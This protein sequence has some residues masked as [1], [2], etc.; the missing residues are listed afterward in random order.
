MRRPFGKTHRLLCQFLVG[1]PLLGRSERLRFGFCGRFYWWQP[2]QQR[3]LRVP[4]IIT[5]RLTLRG[6]CPEDLDRLAVILGDPS[7]M[8]YMPGGKPLPR[9]RTE[10]SLRKILN[11]WERRGYGRWA[12]THNADQC[13]IGWCG[14]EYLAETDETAVVCLLDSPF[15]NRGL[16]TEAVHASLR[17]AF[18][19]LGL[20]RVVGLAH[21]E[22]AAS[23]RLMEKNG[24]VFQKT[25]RLWEM[26]LVE[27]AITGE[28]FQS[29]EAHYRVLR[30]DV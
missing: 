21:T 23:R 4:S 18:E 9:R 20:G 14:L 27:Y 3:T 22:N 7:V 28:G 29:D 1:V 12:V 2:A 19:E 24:L 26:D 11:S 5:E 17:Y 10:G 16:A 30:R 15:W 13:L 25:T 8:R 6:F